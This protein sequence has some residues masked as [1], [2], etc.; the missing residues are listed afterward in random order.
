RDDVDDGE[1]QDKG[2][3]G[4]DDDPDPLARQRSPERV[5]IDVARERRGNC[6]CRS[7]RRLCDRHFYLR[8]IL[9]LTPQRKTHRTLPRTPTPLHWRQLQS[10]KVEVGL[11][12]P[13]LGRKCDWHYRCSHVLLIM[14]V[15]NR[16]QVF[17]R[18]LSNA[19]HTR[20]YLALPSASRLPV[21]LQTTAF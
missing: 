14:K 13:I 6:F 15:L 4:G 16:N 5:Q 10:I 1:R 17:P 12:R 18:R 11:I 19:A 2:E 7:R 9:A 8:L 3:H 21:C 20:R